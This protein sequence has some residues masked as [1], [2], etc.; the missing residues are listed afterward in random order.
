M[1]KNES[2][3]IN[4]DLTYTLPL[5]P[6]RQYSLETIFLPIYTF[7]SKGPLLFLSEMPPQTSP[8]SPSACPYFLTLAVEIGEA[9]KGITEF[10]GKALSGMVQVAEWGDRP[11]AW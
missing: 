9:V 11:A 10:C 8:Q 3:E 7:L 1:E 5:F 4:A 6:R 2:R